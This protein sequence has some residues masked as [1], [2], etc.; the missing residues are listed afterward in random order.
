MQRLGAMA[1]LVALLAPCAAADDPPPIDWRYGEAQY[2]FSLKMFRGFARVPAARDEDGT[3][4]TFAAQ[5]GRPPTLAHPMVSVVQYRTGS[6]PDN[7]WDTTVGTLPLDAAG[8]AALESGKQDFENIESRDEPP[9]KGRLWTFT[10][11]RTEGEPLHVTLA[12]YVRD[13]RAYGIYMRCGASLAPAFAKGFAWIAWSFRFSDER[14]RGTEVLRK[15]MDVDISPRRRREIE[16]SLIKGWDIHVS[17]KKNYV[18]VYNQGNARHFLARV[19]A[20]RVEQ[21]RAERFETDFPPAKPITT[22]SL[23]RLCADRREYH[24]YGGPGGS[25]GYWSRA[26]N[27]FVIYDQSRSKKPDDGTFQM[28]QS[29]AFYQYLHFASGGVEVHPWF[30]NGVAD[31]YGGTVKKGDK[32]IVKPHNWR[33]ETIRSAVVAGQRERCE[34][35]DDRGGTKTEWGN[36]GYTPL[37]DFVRLSHRDFA[38]YPGVSFAQA[39]SLVYFLSKIV[40]ANKEYA[41]KWGRILDTYYATLKTEKHKERALEA[42]FYG[43][44]MEALE[45]AWLN[46]TR[47]TK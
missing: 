14:A 8:K 42:A 19:L 25:A 34:V 26:D 20:K 6:R 24:T 13:G 32:L 21:I 2:K 40:P 10:L 17:P 46:S 18:V 31:Y 36:S 23:I 47:R 37:G 9:V 27:E 33:V 30:L 7:I 35:P 15:L 1:M 3:A 11:S 39:W 45:A 41:A 43:I 5:G 44:D 22:V 12:E 28:L 38:S 29:T 4:S 16:R